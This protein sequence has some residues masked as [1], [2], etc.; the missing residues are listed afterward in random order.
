VGSVNAYKTN[1]RDLNIWAGLGCCLYRR[2]RFGGR[3]LVNS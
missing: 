1:Q 3:I 2:C